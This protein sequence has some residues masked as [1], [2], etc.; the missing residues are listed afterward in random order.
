VAV[1]LQEDPAVVL[2]EEW[3]RDT[4]WQVVIQQETRLGPSGSIQQWLLKEESPGDT[5]PE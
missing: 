3:W 4:I 5:I 1:I 2:K